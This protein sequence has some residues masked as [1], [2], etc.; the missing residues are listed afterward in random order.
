M[1]VKKKKKSKRRRGFVSEFLG[2]KKEPGGWYFSL[3]GHGSRDVLR[4]PFRSEEQA[5]SERDRAVL[6]THPLALLNF[7]PHANFH[8]SQKLKLPSRELLYPTCG[9]HRVRKRRS[10][11]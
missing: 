8:R 2:V 1:R 10:N 5:A 4:G 9:P 11:S 3:P 7:P 6:E